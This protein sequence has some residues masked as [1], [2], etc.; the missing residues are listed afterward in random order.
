M[1]WCLT[2]LSV[3]EL[4]YPYKLFRILKAPHCVF[5]SSPPPPRVISEKVFNVSSIITEFR[6]ICEKNLRNSFCFC[7]SFAIQFELKF[8]SM[9]VR[10]KLRVLN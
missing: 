9:W 10:K 4:Q 8:D 7:Y 5:G 3:G 6:Q 2:D 1:L